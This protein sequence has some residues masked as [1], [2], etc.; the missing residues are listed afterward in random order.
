MAYFHWQEQLRKPNHQ[1]DKE[2]VAW[3]LALGRHV[4]QTEQCIFPVTYNILQERHAS[5][6]L[7]EQSCRIRKYEK[8]KLACSVEM[9][10]WGPRAIRG[11]GKE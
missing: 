9:T 4:A 1:K 7:L 2:R 3:V 8:W 5:I 10:D 6:I 11:R